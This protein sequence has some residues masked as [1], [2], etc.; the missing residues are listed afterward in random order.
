MS[1]QPQP[2]DMVLGALLA[3]VLAWPGI[4]S[5]PNTINPSTG[6]SPGQPK[7]AAPGVPHP[8][9]PETPAVQA[10]FEVGNLRGSPF[11]SNSFT[12]GDPSQN[13][14]RRVDLPWPDPATH[15]SDYQDVQVLNTLD[16]FNLQPRLSIPF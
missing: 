14:G 9:G 5:N 10:R 3:C 1:R 7:S 4:A 11:P 13:T 16:G 12:V 6:A 2:G 15:P 8:C